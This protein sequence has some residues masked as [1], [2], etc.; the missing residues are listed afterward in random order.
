[1]NFRRLRTQDIDINLTPLIDVVFLLLIFFMVST[2]FTKESRIEIDLPESSSKISAEQTTPVEI[3]IDKNGHY[4]INGIALANHDLVTLITALSE[5]DDKE[6]PIIIAADKTTPYQAVITA[7]D[8]A[9]KNGLMHI[10][11]PTSKNQ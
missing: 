3:V 7:L 11:L 10:S 4:R 2:T 6:T 8:A 1:M 5:Y 9:A